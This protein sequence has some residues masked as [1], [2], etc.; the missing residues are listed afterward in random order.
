MSKP[1]VKRSNMRHETWT[2]R[3]CVSQYATW[4]EWNTSQTVDYGVHLLE[5]RR[6]ASVHD[7]ELS[8][9]DRCELE[10]IA[11]IASELNNR[12]ANIAKRHL[13]RNAHRKAL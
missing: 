8:K 11:G 12:A 5:E 3:A 4:I 9:D 7:Y 10:I 1:K 13:A 6:T 2:A